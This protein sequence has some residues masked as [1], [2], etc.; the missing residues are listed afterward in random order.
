VG[1]FCIVFVLEILEI[2]GV[3]ASITAASDR[4]AMVVLRSDKGGV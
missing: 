4:I 2:A 1:K 3:S